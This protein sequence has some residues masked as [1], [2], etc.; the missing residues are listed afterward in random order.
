M[1]SAA[2]S[3]AASGALRLDQLKFHVNALKGMSDGDCTGLQIYIVPAKTESLAL[4]EPYRQ[5]NSVHCFET[6]TFDGC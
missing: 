5:R 2:E 6:V 1:A 3:A 4:P